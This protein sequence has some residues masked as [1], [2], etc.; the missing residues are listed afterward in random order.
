[1]EHCTLC[2]F[3]HRYMYTDSYIPAF[4]NTVVRYQLVLSE[5]ENVLRMLYG[6]NS[7]FERYHYINLGKEK[8]AEMKL[9]VTLI[10]TQK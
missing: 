1:M 2:N 8:I 3:Q 6:L 9:Y 5:N 7:R 4:I 10:S